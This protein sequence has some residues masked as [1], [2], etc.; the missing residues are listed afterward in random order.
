MDPFTLPQPSEAKPEEN[1]P[2]RRLKDNI[3]VDLKLGARLRLVKTV[4]SPPL[5]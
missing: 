4:L 1:R 2:R 3:K 5:P